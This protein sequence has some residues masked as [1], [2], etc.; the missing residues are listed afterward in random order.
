MNFP[1]SRLAEVARGDRFKDHLFEHAA[2]ELAAQDAAEGGGSSATVGIDTVST[3]AVQQQKMEETA[4]RRLARVGCDSAYGRLTGPLI[5]GMA[6]TMPSL[7]LSAADTSGRGSIR[8]SSCGLRDAAPTWWPLPERYTRAADAFDQ[9]HHSFTGRAERLFKALRS[10][11]TSDAKSDAFRHAVSEVVANRF[12]KPMTPL[13]ATIV[14]R[15]RESNPNNGIAALQDEP[16]ASTIWTPRSKW[17]DSKDLLD[18]EQV[19]RLRLNL[20]W[21]RALACRLGTFIVKQDDDGMQDD[22]GDGIC[23]EVAEVLEVFWDHHVLFVAVFEYYASIGGDSV[24]SISLNEWT[25]FVEGCGLVNAK[26]KF[27]KRADMDRLFIA[28]DGASSG[29]DGSKRDKKLGRAE[30]LQGLVR[31]A[32]ARYVMPGKMADVSEALEKLLLEDIRPKLSPLLFVPSNNFRVDCCYIPETTA[33]LASHES[34]LRVI[35]EAVATRARG[36][37]AKISVQ[38]GLLLSLPDWVTLLRRLDLMGP[39][40]SEDEA[41]QAFVFSRMAVIDGLSERGKL[42]E[43]NLPFEGFLEALVRASMAKALPTDEFLAKH[44]YEDAGCYLREL[45]ELHPD[46]Y[47]DFLENPGNRLSETRGL[48]PVWRA[49]DQLIRLIVRTIEG[50]ATGGFKG[51]DDGK[52]TDVEMKSWYHAKYETGANAR[53]KGA[54]MGARNGAD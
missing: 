4:A 5:D 18:S 38:L 28:V 36:C 13:G 21:S 33:V 49:T 24:H 45:K 11:I 54:Q 29:G 42:K 31:L 53:E 37:S 39:D 27:C 22:D 48:Q 34:E 19:E 51:R 17:S 1:I 8:K 32:V 16:E 47:R 44:G 30:F 12:V 6:P 20:D 14:V 25:L 43:R 9:R 7:R 35:F 10:D 2:L 23:D 15:A 26:S 50:V 3:L 46:Q 40:L 41:F 52:L